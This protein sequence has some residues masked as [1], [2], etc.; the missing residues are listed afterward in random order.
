MANTFKKTIDMLAWRQVAPSPNAHAAA[1]CLASDLRSGLSR[2]PFVYQLVSN[3]VLNRYNVVTKAWNLVQS[4]CPVAG[5]R[6]KPKL[7]HLELH[8]SETPQ[9]PHSSL[10]SFADAS[11][12]LK[13]EDASE[14]R[15]QVN[16]LREKLERYIKEHPD[17]G[18]I[19]MLLSG[20]L[21]KG[22]ALKTI[23]DIDVALYVDSTKAPNQEAEL[24]QWL[25]DRL[26]EA[27]PQMQPSQ[28]S[29]GNHC[30]RI[31]FR[32]TG[33][34]VDVVPVH[35]EGDPDD[36]G[37][38]YARD[39][40]KR[41]L[42]SIP[43]HLKFT[44]KRKDA[45]SIHFA[46]CVRLAK[47]WASIQKRNDDQFRFKSFMSELVFAKLADQGTVLSDYPRALE[48][49][50]SYVVKSQ[51]RER[52]AFTDYYPANRLPAPTGSAI[53]I[54]DPVNSENNV[55]SDYSDSHR[56]AII[57]RA[58]DCF[59]A[60]VEARYATTKS[61]AVDLWQEVLGPSFRG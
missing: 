37:Y 49:F 39:T 59:E 56:N 55:A 3:T 35:Y 45:N 44:R 43:L 6:F 18:L 36:R 29:P 46:Q 53:E 14:Y 47:W 54:F 33:L 19:K 48:S 30:V 2:N 16:N 28:I 11:V 32:G 50:F 10:V 8:M 52:V 20:S 17:V 34:D 31:S 25:A 1:A 12:N 60:I 26:R 4:P 9:I 22:L 58:Q 27:Y 40:G 7:L 21:A 41:V 51:L 13:R 23:N 5:L 38:L 15:K 24:L 61:R 57:A 42:T